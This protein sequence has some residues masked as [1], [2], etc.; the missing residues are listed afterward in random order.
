MKKTIKSTAL[1]LGLAS[2]ALVAN[3]AV[4]ADF[5]TQ[6]VSNSI[7]LAE[8]DPR[9]IIGRIIQIALSL[10]GAVALLIIMYAGFIWTTSNGDEEKIGRAKKILRDA[11]IGLVI[12]L[13]S[14]AITTFVLSRLV[15]SIGGGQAIENFSESRANLSA[16]GAGAAGACSVDS[17][18]PDNGQKDV[19]RNVS[20]IITFKEVFDADFIAV[21]NNGE[22]CAYAEGQC[23]LINP[24]TIRVYKTDLGDACS[25]GDCAADNS[26]VTAATVSFSS[27]QK[28]LVI[29]PSTYLGEADKNVSYTVKISDNLKKIDGQSMFS[30]CSSD[31]FSWSFEVSTET[32]L[33]P[34]QVLSG[35]MSPLPDNENDSENLVTVALAA[36]GTIIVEDIPNIYREAVVESVSPIGSSPLATASALAYQGPVTSFLVAIPSESTSKAQLLKTEGNEPLAAA[37]FDDQGN[38]KFSGYFIFKAQAREAGNSWRVIV[39]PGQAADTLTIGKQVYTFSEKESG[40]NNIQIAGQALVDEAAVAREIYSVLSGDP[41][42]NVSHQVGSKQITLAAKVAGVDG[43]EIEVLSTNAGTLSVSPLSGGSNRQEETIIKGRRDVPMNTAIQI[44]FSEPINP[45]KIAGTA[46]EVAPYIRVINHEASSSPAG[47]SCSK[48]SDCRSYKCEGIV[49]NK[50]CVGDYVNGTFIASNNYR[51]LEFIS[52]NECAVNGCGE[53]IYCLPGGSHLAVEMRASDLKACNTDSDCVSFAPFNACIA[54]PLGYKTCQDGENNNYPAASPAAN[55]LVD[56]AANSLDGNRNVFADGPLS[57]YNDN[58]GAADN[59]GRKDNYRWSFYVSNI[60]NLTPPRIESISPAQGQKGFPLAEPIKIVW[61]TLML[62]SSLRSGSRAVTTGAALVEH[63]LLNIWSSAGQAL[64]YWISND[65]IDIEPKDGE[66]DRTITWIKHTP[67][68]ESASYDVQAG[69]GIKDIY[70][71]CYKPSAGVSCAASVT[72]PSC[73]FGQAT[74]TLGADGNCR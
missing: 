48:N 16:F 41:L 2:L 74:S 53:K 62:N 33:T 73:C 3:F 65:N 42:I 60:I 8:A 46:S 12:I 27:D 59:S 63:K 4:A 7:S 44:N 14:W 58:L 45:L 20:I 1:L 69:S 18:Y 54:S 6:A 43:N 55:G 23:D 72:V 31:Y 28:T 36:Q 13:S 47:T 57:F 67:F 38:A 15:Q 17:F 32:D 40:G 5:G 49:G 19:A 68:S 52:D 26:N 25:S 30:S 21:N 34:P 64:G 66:P 29:T 51:T 56:L 22:P 11:V 70:Q 35:S 39:R 50:A 10:L 24:E 61:N 9:V 37:D 71:N